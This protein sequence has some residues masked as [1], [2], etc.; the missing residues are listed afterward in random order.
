M[1]DTNKRKTNDAVALLHRRYV[2]DD[3]A[4]KASL[5]AERVSANVAQ[6]IHDLREDAG[7]SQ[8]EL[9]SLKGE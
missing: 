4:R 1:K 8:T 2:G 5:E 3:P 9:A 7:L 6:M